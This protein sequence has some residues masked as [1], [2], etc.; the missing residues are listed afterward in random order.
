MIKLKSYCYKV[1]ICLIKPIKSRTM[2]RI[3]LQIAGYEIDPETKK[4]YNQKGNEIQVKDGKLRL[5]DADGIRRTYKV[6]DI[7]A[8]LEEPKQ[9]KAATEKKQAVKVEDSTNNP[10][11]NIEDIQRKISKLV[12]GQDVSFTIYKSDLIITGEYK[13]VSSF[14]LGLPC[15][16][17]KIKGE[18]RQRKVSFNSIII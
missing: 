1:Y 11:K 9:K 13:G 16:I 10:H 17:V 18:K 12:K 2:N 8:S 4:I 3:K 5:F 7:T 6:E 15:A 14:R